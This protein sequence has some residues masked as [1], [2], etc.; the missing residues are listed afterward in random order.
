MTDRYMTPD[1]RFVDRDEK[2]D[3]AERREDRYERFA[4]MT[5]EEIRQ[6]LELREKRDADPRHG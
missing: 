4:E 6:A 5:D 1:E 3:A 2:S